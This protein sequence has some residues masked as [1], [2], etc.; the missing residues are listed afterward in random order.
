MEHI[1]NIINQICS[2]FDFAYMVTINALTYCIIKI[3]DNL[4]GEKKVSVLQKRIILVCSIIIVTGF[5]EL[6]DYPNQ[7]VLINSAIL[8]PVF[9]SWVLRPILNKFGVGYKQIDETLCK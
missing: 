3:I 9:W 6:V 2:D 5:Y 8:A 1:N 4:N 7:K